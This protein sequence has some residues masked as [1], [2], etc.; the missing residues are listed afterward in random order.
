MI[1]I[2]LLLARDNLTSFH[3]LHI[4][5][6]IGDW[7]NFLYFED[8]PSINPDNTLLVNGPQG[9][10]DWYSQLHQQGYK[11]LIDQLWGAWKIDKEDCFLLHVDNWFW[12][13]SC[14]LYLSRG[15]QNYI[16]NKNYSKLALMP[17]GNLRDERTRL[18]NKVNSHLDN[19]VWSYVGLTGKHLPD[20][21]SDWQ[22]VFYFNPSWY[23][24]TYFSIVSE[25][26]FRR[27][28]GPDV[29][30]PN[31]LLSEK[32]FKPIA[33]RHPFIVWGQSGVL[34]K[35]KELGF[36]TYNN[37]FDESYDTEQDEATR[38]DKLVANISL[39][40]NQPYD[41]LTLD[42][43]QHNYELF[44]NKEIVLDRI[45]QEIVL[46]ILDFFY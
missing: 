16:P 29:F 15:Y 6:A 28:H 34:K 38:L 3:E 8:S 11:L 32:I 21:L 44:F 43:I 26:S 5:Q 2:N 19:F 39:V 31:L 33:F 4:Q 27:L 35:L 20:D 46:P 12:Y 45:K 14:S 9:N 10:T 1:K 23:D 40:A 42:K 41:K 17:L 24:D 18:Y 22:D 36:E 13:Y 37:L 7:F 30:V 25:T